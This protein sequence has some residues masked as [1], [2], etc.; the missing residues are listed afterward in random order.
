[1]LHEP[2]GVRE[3]GKTFAVPTCLFSGSAGLMIIVGLGREAFGG[4]LP[5]VTWQQGTVPAAH[6]P[7]G[8]LT[9]QPC[10]APGDGSRDAIAPFLPGSGR[11]NGKVD[12]AMGSYSRLPGHPTWLEP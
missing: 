3:N 8:R 4:G 7:S 12:A 10:R 11:L 5:H 2:A 9:L 6:H 1:V